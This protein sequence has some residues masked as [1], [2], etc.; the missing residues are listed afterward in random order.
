MRHIPNIFIP[1]ST[2]N[3]LLEV[4]IEKYD[5]FEIFWYHWN[6]DGPIWFNLLKPEEDF[7]PVILVYDSKDNFIS[8]ITRRHWEYQDYY[9]DEDEL[10][11]PPTILFD[12]EFHPPFPLTHENADWFDS[13]IKIMKPE[14]YSPKVID[15]GKIDPKFRIGKSHKTLPLQPP[16]LDPHDVAQEI[17]AKFTN[18]S[19]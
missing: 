7:E 16:V 5:N 8:L 15:A 19:I 14:N 6:F 2:D 17:Q 9:V 3:P 4:F 11:I 18:T 12:G 13:K 10:S 1:N